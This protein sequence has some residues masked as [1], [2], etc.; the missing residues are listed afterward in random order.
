MWIGGARWTDLCTVT[1]HWFTGR[2]LVREKEN[3]LNL[4]IRYILLYSSSLGD[5]ECSL[6]DQGSLDSNQMDTMYN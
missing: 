5:I 2:V 3:M 4:I 1:L 6:I